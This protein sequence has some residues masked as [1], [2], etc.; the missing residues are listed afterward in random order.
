[1]IGALGPVA[2]IYLAYVFL[3]EQLSLT[4]LAGSGLVL[5]GVMMISMRKME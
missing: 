5:I 2:T 4:Q 3:A 1:M